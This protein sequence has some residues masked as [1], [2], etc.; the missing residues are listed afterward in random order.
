MPWDLCFNGILRISYKEKEVLVPIS[1]SE[2]PTPADQN[3]TAEEAKEYSESSK[4]SE[5]SDS[6]VTDSADGTVGIA[7]GSTG[8]VVVLTLISAGYYCYKKKHAKISKT[9]PT[10]SGGEFGQKDH[11]PMV[12]DVSLANNVL[13]LADNDNSSG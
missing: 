10:S 4:S 1:D 5:S 8:G 9:M 6:S 3:S 7:L 13:D 11:N 12:T 2:T